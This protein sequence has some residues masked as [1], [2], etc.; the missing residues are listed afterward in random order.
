[1]SSIGNIECP[2]K[3]TLKSVTPTTIYYN[4]N[5]GNNSVFFINNN[6]ND[7]L[8]RNDVV[9]TPSL[10]NNCLDLVSSETNFRKSCTSDLLTH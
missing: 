3:R 6:A 9:A 4:V 10:F 2:K 7:Y 8:D 5:N 1:M